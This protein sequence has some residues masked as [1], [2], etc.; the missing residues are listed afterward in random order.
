MSIGEKQK[1]F[2]YEVAPRDGLQN[3]P[4][5]VE[6]KDK[7]V[8][9][10]MLSESGFKKIETTS[11]TSPRAIPALG[12]ADELMQSIKRNPKVTYSALV[13]NLRGLQRAVSAN[14]EEANFVLSC[15]ETHN[16]VNLRMS[17]EDSLAQLKDVVE[18][19]R[20]NQININTSLSTAFGCPM[21]GEVRLSEVI[22]V[23]ERLTSLGV[24]SI[25]LCDT[26]GMAYPDQVSKTCS[27]LK[28]LYPS[29]SVTLHLHNT[30]GLALANA[31]AALNVG[32]N[33]FD[34]SLGGLGG[35]P[36]A[37]G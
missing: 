35:C 9:L 10:N 7:V 29:V 13:P 27:Q 21:E 28:K 11:F 5:F 1:V 22:G 30:R 4:K 3:E 23:V 8:L 33:Q 17:R 24:D 14:V 6:T 12:D 34:S 25:T 31:L 20:E 16:R 18:V 19:G 26:T 2:I 36:Y 15:S 32:I 37:P